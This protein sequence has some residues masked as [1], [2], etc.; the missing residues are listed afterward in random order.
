MDGRKSSREAHRPRRP[1][2]FNVSSEAEQNREGEQPK[3][4]V[5]P[6]SLKFPLQKGIKTS[7][8]VIEL[9]KGHNASYRESENIN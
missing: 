7:R 2:Q 1:E 9:F 5:P 4:W 8:I 3:G 6:L